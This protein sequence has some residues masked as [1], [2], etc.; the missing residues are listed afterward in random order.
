MQL[1]EHVNKGHFVGTSSFEGTRMPLQLRRIGGISEEEHAADVDGK[2][3][4]ILMN[5]DGVELG[6]SSG[7]PAAPLLLSA[8]TR[9]DKHSAARS[10][11]AAANQPVNRGVRQRERAVDG[12]DR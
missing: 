7:T 4:E 8:S 10:G 6:G 12:R 2:V 11:S 5:N 1:K 9:K 3:A